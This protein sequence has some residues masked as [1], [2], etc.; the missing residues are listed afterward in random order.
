MTRHSLNGS[1]LSV[2]SCLLLFAFRTA[3]GSYDGEKW[4]FLDAGRVLQAAK[5]ITQE[6]FPDCDDATV[7]KKMVRVYRADGTGESQDETYVKVLTEKGKRESR[8]LSLFYMLPYS[9]AEVVRLEVIKPG[10]EIV[11]VDLAANSKEMID[12]SQMGSNIYDPNAKILRVN[13][14]NLE[15]GD[16]LHAVTR[17]TIQRAI[18]EGE[19][20]DDELFEGPGYLRHATYEI[21]A[22]ADK[23]LKKIV[24]RDEVPGTVLYDLRAVENNVSLHR[25]EVKNVP[26]MFNE[27]GMPPYEITLQRLLVSTTADWKAVSRWYWY[28]SKPHLDATTPELLHTVA[29]L[30]AGAR[31][32]E[33]KIKALF[34]HVAQKIRYMGLT[35]EK[36]R[37]GFE[38][39]DVKLTFN[40][41]YGVCRD[42]AALLVSMLGAAG[43]HSYPVLMNVGM[44]RDQE[45]PEPAFNHAIVGV[46]LKKGEY[47]LMDPTAENTKDLLPSYECDQS[48]LVCTP[49]GETLHASPILP[50][51]QN[52]LR[53][54]TTGSL[55][56]AG[57]LEGKSELAFDGINDNTYR[58]AFSRMKP[59]DKRRFFERALKRTMPGAQL[60]SLQLIP[61]DAQDTSVALRAVIEFSAAGLV[62]A[63][64]GKAVVSLPWIGKGMGMVNF[65]LGDAGLD[66]RKYPLRTDVACGVKEEIALTLA[67]DFS[68]TV[69]MPHYA[70]IHDGSISYQRAAELKGGA[71]SGRGELKLQTVEFSPAQYLGLRKALETMDYDERKALVLAVSGTARPGGRARSTATPE[72]VASNAPILESRKE[73]E[74]V[75][76]HTE[77]LTG[78]YVKKILTYSGKKNE[79][80][81]KFAFNPSCESAKILRA[82]VTSK[83]GQRQELT[84]NEINV[85]DAGWNASAKRYTGGKILVANLPGVDI[86]STIEVDYQLASKGKPFLSGFEPFQSFDELQKKTFTVKAPANLPLQTRVSGPPGVVTGTNYASAGSAVAQWTAARVKA[87][88]AESQ[89]PPEWIYLAGVDYFAGRWD[90]YLDG[91]HSALLARSRES[92]KAAQLARDLAAPASDKRA[93]VKAIRDYVARR[94]RLAGPAFTQLPL[95]ELSA[96]DTTLADGYGHMADRAILL[97]SMLSAAGFAPEF[98]LASS[99]PAIDGITNVT[100]AFPLP[101]NFQWPLVRVAVEGELYYLNDTDQYA[102]LGSVGQ[103]GRLGIVLAT[104]ASEVIHAAQNCGDKAETSYTLSISDSGA[105]R[106][107]ITHRYFGSFYNSKNRYFSELPPEERNRYYQEIVSQVAQGARPVGE[108][109]TKFDSYPGLEQFTVEIDNYSVVDGRYAYFDLPF[110]PSLYPV[111]ADTRALPLFISHP[112]QRTIR[113]E[114]QLPPHFPQVDLAPANE[115]LE[116][117]HGA[118]TAEI[119]LAQS[120]GKRVLTHRFETHSAIV[121]ASDYPELLQAEAVLG[122]KSSRVFLLEA[123]GGATAAGAPR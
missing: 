101:R 63:G 119:S 60:K 21:Y 89:L 91:L 96:A 69:S 26:R 54:A 51:E 6:K 123:A 121:A 114:I 19:F 35:P 11:P 45:V 82:I 102:Q 106:I 109:T 68:G 25:W 77:T 110:A 62:A 56:A 32:D 42:K 117:A 87:L 48:Y 108:L 14:P 46:E 59:D 12:D 76:A 115:K 64:D 7:D 81:V 73:L 3:A 84:T 98:V 116:V 39:H 118:G 10:G 33:E 61:E 83:T 67:P 52:L 34:Y 2:L 86:G 23:P 78:H 55:N 58:E 66:K 40:N 65:I 95:S 20:A 37:P 13:I 22:P 99:L 41:K 122:G 75:D 107:G 28:L 16:L 90:E 72:A 29:E 44:K 5:E 103:D 79:A 80:E 53:I 8:S 50:A 38:P 94:I 71:L 9:T 70:S 30:T 49:D 4:S 100:S 57:E 74:I 88:P 1:F 18:M 92:T 27:P 120:G 112:S 97:H 31:T 113:T 111:G 93:A 47:L 43:F 24:L 15:I 17:T 105:T 104:R 85:M 36:D